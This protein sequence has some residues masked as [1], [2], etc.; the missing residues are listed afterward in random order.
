[1]VHRGIASI[2]GAMIFCYML[3]AQVDTQFFFLHFYEA[4]MYLAIILMLFYLEDRWAYMLGILTPAVWL[5]L[6]VANGQLLSPINMLV[7]DRTSP[8][9]IGWITVLTAVVAV[10]MIA[11]CWRHW[12]REFSGSGKGLSTFAVSLVI[13]VVYYGILIYWFA[14]LAPWN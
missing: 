11:G 3:L 13:V 8:T 6:V 2:S 1:M 14:S 12:K 5:L 7:V 10:I 4:L 9:P